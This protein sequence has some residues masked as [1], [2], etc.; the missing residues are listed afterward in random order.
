MQHLILL[1]A[2]GTAEAVIYLLRY[3][4]AVE[5]SAWKSGVHSMLVCSLRVTFIIAGVGAMLESTNPV[6]L[7]LA[8]ALP[9][10]ITTGLLHEYLER[11]K[12]EAAG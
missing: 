5:R 10:A 3:R 9:A 1:A 8:Y 11:S 2:I 7:G 6:A 4:S 12:R